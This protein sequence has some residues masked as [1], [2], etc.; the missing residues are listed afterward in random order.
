MNVFQ[1]IIEGIKIAL[2][3][4]RTSKLRAFLTM[5]GVAT[6]IFAIT[7]IL[8]MVNSLERSITD[9]LSSLGNTTLFVHHWPWKDNSQ[10]W[11]KYFNR[12]QVSYQDFQRLKQKLDGV[13][14]VSFQATFSGQVVKAGGQSV[15]QTTVNGVTYDMAA[16]SSLE[17]E[18]GRYFSEVED[19][20]GSSVCL[21][22]YNIA[23]GL[24]PGKPA[25]GDYVRLRGKRLRVVG[26][27]KKQGG[28]PFGPS[29]IDDQVFVPYRVAASMYNLT[30]R[31][32]DKVITVKALSYDNLDYVE[33][34]IIGIVRTSR[35]LKPNQENNFAINKQ[36]SLMEMIGAFFAVLKG[37]GYIISFFSILIGAF[38]IGMIMYISVR[39]RT[40][41]IGIQ[42]AL[43]ATRPFILFQFLAES[44]IICL[45]GGAM[46]L[47]LVYGVAAT[48][49]QIMESMNIDMNIAVTAHEVSLGLRFAVITGLVSGLIPATIAATMDPVQ[50]IRHA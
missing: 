6:G 14:G 22:G 37:G 9:N 44:V 46:G 4:I 16:I 7:S 38:S 28:L 2:E 11:Y 47:A 23:E 33:N 24:F 40:N 20:V 17:F 27:I 34:E 42:K 8:T 10:D 35:G 15:E 19:Q 50:A 13:S 39:E 26:I 45:L 32:V 36:E 21:L 30:R 25:L 29:S 18:E 31:S 12:P 5:L 43:G 48:A 49:Q 3:A 1:F 41:E